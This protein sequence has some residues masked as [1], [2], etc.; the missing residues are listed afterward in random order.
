MKKFAILISAILLISTFSIGTPSESA[1]ILTTSNTE[2]GNNTTQKYHTYESMT[3]ELQGIAN[4]Y[5]EIVA[6]YDIT[7]FTKYGKTWQGRSV[8][9]VK[10][11]DN[12]Q[13]NELNEPKIIIFGAHHAREW[14][15]F[16]VPLYFLNFLID[17]YKKQ[18]TDNDNDGKINEDD[19]D[20][21]DN[22]K[23]DLTD[24]DWNEARISWI[25]DNR[26]IWIIPMVNPDGVAYDMTISKEGDSG[27][28]WRKNLRDN[29]G[30][31]EFDPDYDGV[32]I[33]R[34]YPYMWS[35]ND[36]LGTVDEDGV[37]VHVDDR[38]PAS[39]TYHG[40]E[41]NYDDDGDAVVPVD[42]IDNPTK[43]NQ[44]IDDHIDEDPYD[45][46]D[47]DKDGKIDEDKDGG[48]SE[49]ETMAIEEL[50]KKLDSDGNYVNR[51]SDVS[52]GIS[53]HSYSELVIW[54]WGYTSD[55]A[56]HDAL[57]TYIG[58]NMA[59]FN[60][61]TPM[62]ST[63]LYPTSGDLD[64]WMYGS[65]G[66]LQFTVELNSGEEGGFHPPASLIEN[67]S[68]KN[69]GVNIYAAE[70][71]DKAKSAFVANTPDLNIPYPLIINENKEE[72]IFSKN[73]YVV[74]VKVENGSALVKNS[75]VLH[76]R[77]NNGEWNKI[78][79]QKD[80]KY[81]SAIIPKQS[82]GVVD[83]YIEGKY[84]YDLTNGR[85]SSIFYPKYAPYEVMSYE[86][87]N[88]KT[89]F[90]VW[91]YGII[92]GAIVIAAIVYFIRREKSYRL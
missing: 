49:P 3:M 79:M 42:I 71:A 21:I 65:M 85:E 15:S 2:S 44:Y 32:D 40:P 61:Y 70:I 35:K 81:F 52:I 1:P 64:D 26:E 6:L 20:G 67:T 39:D 4:E 62:K 25:I 73:D 31:G 63:D 68:K 77:V 30:D 91:I 7:S 88:D 45:F 14:M 37:T 22:D 60:G 74:R 48:F 87:K 34:N 33:N 36:D 11:S 66:V 56:P 89:L 83:Y 53:Y 12:P 55:K 43:R 92:V 46:I 24:E 76:Y 38:N 47:N 80:G 59:K 84:I 54:P 16:E 50:M 75:L 9:G 23:D 58:K 69:L 10:V 51:H 78:V 41:D 13:V 8:W 5:P 17:N 19:I 90:S 86:I 57:F 29:D 27:S 18:P 82:S 72:V 28:G